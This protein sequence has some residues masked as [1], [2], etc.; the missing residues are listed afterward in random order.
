MAIG[1]YWPMAEGWGSPSVSLLPTN[2][3]FARD[4]CFRRV[5]SYLKSLIVILGG[6]TE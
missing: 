3:T 4:R 2:S 1:V 5:D 6:T